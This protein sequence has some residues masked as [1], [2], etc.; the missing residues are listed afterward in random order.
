MRVNICNVYLLFFIELLE[1]KLIFRNV[2]YY[3]KYKF[4]SVPFDCSQFP[5]WPLFYVSPDIYI[6]FFRNAC[7]SVASCAIKQTLFSS[8]SCKNLVLLKLLW[9]ISDICLNPG[10]TA[11]NKKLVVG[12]QVWVESAESDTFVGT[13][14]V[15]TGNI[16]HV[17]L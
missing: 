16:I 2:N 1:Y 4:L 17:D 15:F 10:G 3:W 5:I 13:Y 8:K 14:S 9:L 11:V 12:D 6:Y 7:N